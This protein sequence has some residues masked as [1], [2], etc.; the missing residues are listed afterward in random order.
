MTAQ[1]L[2]TN[3]SQFQVCNTKW[4]LSRPPQDTYVMPCWLI[5][6]STFVLVSLCI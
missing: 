1:Y 2:D 3:E 5:S 4:L 6:P